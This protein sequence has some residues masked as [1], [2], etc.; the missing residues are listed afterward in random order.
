MQY[1]SSIPHSIFCPHII[2][3]F[4]MPC[5][6][7]HPLRTTLYSLPA[8]TDIYLT[9]PN[10]IPMLYLVVLVHCTALYHASTAFNLIPLHCTQ[11]YHGS[12]AGF[13]FILLKST[14]TIP[15]SICTLLHS[16]MA[17][18]G[19]YFHPILL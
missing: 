15:D 16:Y 3:Q 12:T 17:L 2:Y 14:M 5:K 7:P 1:F 11:L 4:I 8:S 9:L 13:S 19:F 18:T 6:P 10:P